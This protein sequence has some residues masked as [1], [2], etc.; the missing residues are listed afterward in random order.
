MTS[1]VRRIVP[2]HSAHAQSTVSMNGLWGSKSSSTRIPDRS[3]S[4]R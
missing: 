3:A 4:S 2:S 1:G